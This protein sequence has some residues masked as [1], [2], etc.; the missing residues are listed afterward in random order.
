MPENDEGPY[1]P[2]ARKVERIKTENPETKEA[3]REVAAE[4]R[5]VAASERE[6]SRRPRRWLRE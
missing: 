4:I 3:L 5:G 1:E 6:T 2:I